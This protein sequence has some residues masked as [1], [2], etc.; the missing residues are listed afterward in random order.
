MSRSTCSSCMTL[1][2]TEQNLSL[3]T[4][5][6]LCGLSALKNTVHSNKRCD[7]EYQTHLFSLMATKVLES[8]GDLRCLFPPC[9]SW[10]LATLVE[11]FNASKT[12]N[13]CSID[14]INSLSDGNSSSACFI[15][16]SRHV[17]LSKRSTTSCDKI[18][19][20]N[21]CYIFNA[22]SAFQLLQNVFTNCLISST[23]S[24]LIDFK[25]ILRLTLVAAVSFLFSYLSTKKLK[26]IELF[27]TVIGSPWTNWSAW[28]L[29]CP[30]ANYLI[31]QWTLN[32]C[33]C[34]LKMFSK[35]AK[36]SYF[37]SNVGKDIDGN[38]I[39]TPLD[40]LNSVTE[41]CTV[42]HIRSL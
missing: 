42:R 28:P 20:S 2:E 25:P 39:E 21:G 11:G 10:T 23:S 35:V 40:W 29:K 34:T 19:S 8:G 33:D 24:L 36:S 4:R 17:W 7:L 27:L 30:I 9:V 14:A 13:F 12:R 22:F 41:C 15:C 37:P 31:F 38:F 18:M 1:P 26:A 16:H 32:L 6:L 3:W 5:D